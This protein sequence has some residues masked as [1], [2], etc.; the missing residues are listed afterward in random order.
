MRV[1]GV[2]NASITTGTGS[3]TVALTAQQFR[4]IEEGDRI[5]ELDG[6][7]QKMEMNMRKVYIK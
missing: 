4:T 1:S 3:D 6:W 5:K 2:L 7:S